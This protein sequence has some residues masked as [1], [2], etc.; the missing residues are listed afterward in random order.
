MLR[1]RLPELV[2]QK[3]VCSMVQLSAED[4]GDPILLQTILHVVVTRVVAR[5]VSSAL[6]ASKL[7]AP[8]ACR[9][10]SHAASL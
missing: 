7:P 6:M 1:D 8:N 5:P 3:H 10:A 2:E 9:V 4:A